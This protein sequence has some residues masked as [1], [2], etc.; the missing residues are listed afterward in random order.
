M[1][2]DL[3]I[4]FLFYHCT[5]CILTLWTDCIIKLRLNCLF[6]I[7]ISKTK[8]ALRLSILHLLFHRSNFKNINTENFCECNKRKHHFLEKVSSL[9]IIYFAQV[10]QY[11]KKKVSI[12]NWYLPT[13]IYIY[14]RCQVKLPIQL[15]WS[16]LTR[17]YLAL[18]WWYI[19]EFKGPAFR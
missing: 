18:H 13:H 5:A 10:H 15:C 4:Y 11:S 7:I 17:Q 1:Y 14:Q 16:S 6:V 2:L 3:I 12:T 19:T 9:I 8:C